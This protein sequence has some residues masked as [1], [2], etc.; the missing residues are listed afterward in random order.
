MGFMCDCLFLAEFDN[1]AGPVLRCQAPENFLTSDQFDCISQYL[2]TKKQFCGRL[3]TLTAFGK[4]IMGF[5][6][7]IEDPKYGRNALIFNVGLI[8]S[9]PTQNNRC[10]GRRHGGS[11]G[12]PAAFGAVV[13]KLANTLRTMEC[14]SGTLSE[15][16]HRGEVARILRSILSGINRAGH[17]AVP[18]DSVHTVYLRLG[19]RPAENLPNVY[20]HQV[21]VP[22]LDLPPT[23][24]AG[25]GTQELTLDR[26]WRCIDGVR[27]V[28][29]IAHPTVADVDVQLVRKCVQHLQARGFVQLIDRFQF[30]NVYTTTNCIGR[31]AADVDG[32]Q[33]A[34]ANFVS[35]R[36][37]TMRGDQLV[38]L[39]ASIHAGT[40]IAHFCVKHQREIKELNIDVRRLV[41]FGLLHG[42]LRQIKSYSL[43]DDGHIAGA[44]LC[45]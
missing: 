45:I 35:D 8:L 41:T 5:P 31:L 22:L 6:V 16:G 2:I 44:V 13:G 43:S 26:I 27:S 7:C 21:P 40:T 25:S 15:P 14:E 4:R 3:I 19:E 42:F 28:E 32:C 38:R 23:T 17:C 39:Y 30:S 11:G 1:E 24:C 10:T 36:N 33:V 12:D 18:V 9:L 20:N 37:V 34:C 29:R